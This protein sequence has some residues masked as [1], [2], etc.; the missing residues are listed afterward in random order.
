MHAPRIETG[1]DVGKVQWR[2][3]ERLAHVAPVRG[4]IAG[5]LPVIEA[6]RLEALALVDEGRGQD[7]ALPQKLAFAVEF[8][9]HQHEAIA[10]ADVEHEIDVPAKDIGQFHDHGVAEPGLL[11]G[12]EQ[13]GI[14]DPFCLGDF[15]GDFALQRFRKQ[16]RRPS[17]RTIR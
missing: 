14:D 10:L 17:C 5:V 1:A 3:Q 11:A 4:E 12:D 2:A 8:F 16:V 6:D 15:R 13:R 9:V 7:L